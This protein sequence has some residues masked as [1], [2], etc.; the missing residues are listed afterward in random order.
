MGVLKERGRA[1][2]FAKFVSEYQLP[3]P[4]LLLAFGINLVRVF[5]PPEVNVPTLDDSAPNS[6]S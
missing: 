2:F 3:I 1:V 4:K 6:V 5:F